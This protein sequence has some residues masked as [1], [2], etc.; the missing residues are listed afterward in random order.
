MRYDFALATTTAVQGASVQ[1][2]T[3]KEHSINKQ[4]SIDKTAVM[5][6]KGDK[7]ETICEDKGNLLLFEV[8]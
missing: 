5:K 2:H 4:N 3:W 1:C 7:K 6:R 8:I